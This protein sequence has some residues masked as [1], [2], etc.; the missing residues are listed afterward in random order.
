MPHP[1][2]AA[3]LLKA[4]RNRCGVIAV[5]SPARRDAAASSSPI[6]SGRIGAPIGSR[7]R[8]TTTKSPA[9]AR[10]T[11]IRSN[12]YVSKACTVRKSSGTARCRRTSPTPHWDCRLGGPHAR[13]RG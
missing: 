10:G 7:N 8:L 11:V 5:V 12:T 6:A 2:S 4:C 13:A 3:L 1:A 9:A